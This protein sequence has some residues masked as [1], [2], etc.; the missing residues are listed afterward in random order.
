MRVRVNSISSYSYRPKNQVNFGIIKD[1]RAKR[2]V[3]NHSSYGDEGVKALEDAKY[4]TFHTED[5]E[6]YVKIDMDMIKE[7]F[8]ASGIADINDYDKIDKEEPVAS[9]KEYVEYAEKYNDFQDPDSLTY[10][11]YLDILKLEEKEYKKQQKRAQKEAEREEFMVYDTDPDYL[12]KRAE[13][14]A[15]GWYW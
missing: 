9:L 8:G 13:L 5:R 3:R 10:D 15:Q 12:Q 6:M 14:D 4:L 1:E 7:R 11:E 2:F